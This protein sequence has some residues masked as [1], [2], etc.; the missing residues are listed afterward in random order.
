ME[1]MEKGG[2]VVAVA[3][4]QGG[5]YH[6]GVYYWRSYRPDDRHGVVDHSDCVGVGGSVGGDQGGVCNYGGCDQRGV[7]E[8]QRRPVG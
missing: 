4:G 3:E 5:R 2:P 8:G 1:S 6:W 7:S